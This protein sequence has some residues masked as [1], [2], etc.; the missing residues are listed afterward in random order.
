MGRAALAAAERRARVGRRALVVALGL[1][2]AAAVALARGAFGLAEG[3]AIPG[4]GLAI[5]A[6]AL[7]AR[8]RPARPLRPL[9]EPPGAPGRDAGRAP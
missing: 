6:L 9:S 8:L 3:L 1:S 2:L 4:V 5:G 7:G